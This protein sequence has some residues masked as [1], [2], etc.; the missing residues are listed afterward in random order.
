MPPFLNPDGGDETTLLH[1]PAT[2]GWNAQ[3]FTLPTAASVG[4]S[5]TPFGT[6]QGSVACTSAQNGTFGYQVGQFD[7]LGGA[8][9]IVTTACNDA[10]IGSQA[11]D[12]YPNDGTGFGAAVRY[13][14]PLS[15]EPSGCVQASLVDVTGDYALDYVVTSLCTDSSVGTTQWLV[16]ENSNGA[17]AANPTSYAL[18]ANAALHAFASIEAPTANCSSSQPA[19]G[20][21]DVTGDGIADIV[22]TVACDDANVGVT[23]WRVYPGSA[24]GFG[25]AVA[26]TLPG[27]AVFPSP[28][29]AT[30]SCTPSDQPAY[31]VLDFDGDLKPDL[32]VTKSCT[33]VNVGTSY[34]D[35]YKNT[36]SGFSSAPIQ[37]TLPVLASD[38]ANPFASISGS[39]SCGASGSLTYTLVD[40]DGDRK[41]D[42]V[43]TSACA[44][45]TLGASEWYVYPNT[46][47]TF[48]E[49][50]AY[51]IPSAFDPTTANPVSSLSQSLS[52]SGHAS[53]A[54]TAAY[55]LDTRL[56][57]IET[58]ACNDAA[59]GFTQWLVYTPTCPSSDD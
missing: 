49:A 20:L 35:V 4:A 28:T 45:A 34:W 30:L 31:T 25:A 21:F 14:I 55:L 2:C 54:F 51:A 42:L 7:G 56:D 19:Y 3:S 58:A 48:G 12:V 10:T 33:D 37:P 24:T 16:F 44:N 26:F 57:L 17:F 38:P 1:P 23:D 22:E 46:G 43:A 18:P 11:F 36:G 15:T 59:T 50:L 9:L 13:Q 32:V 41:P 6:L 47:A 8:D 40:V 5:G 29:A 27:A 52:C 39:V 53:P